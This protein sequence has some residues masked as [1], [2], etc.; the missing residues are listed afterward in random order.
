MIARPAGRTRHP[1][2][3]GWSKRPRPRTRLWT[4]RVACCR[5]K[6]RDGRNGKRGA[7]NEA[8]VG[9]TNAGTGPPST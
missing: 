8:A 5:N 1:Q 4:P 9:C 3:R 7:P 2:P 6:Q